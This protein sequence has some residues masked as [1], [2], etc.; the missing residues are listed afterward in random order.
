MIE[1]IIFEI[2]I[3]TVS[4]V[5]SSEHWSK[6]SARHRMQQFFIRAAFNKESQDIPFPCIVKMTR[7]GPRF[8]DDDNLR[9][10]FKWIRDEISECL[11]PEKRSFYIGTNGKPRRIKGQAD[12]DPRITWEYDQE[13]N[14]IQGIRIEIKPASRLPATQM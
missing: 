14:S 9:S 12:S 8:L 5:N 10:A 1:N 3:K 6:K 11:I 2:P 13:K 7:L 4:E